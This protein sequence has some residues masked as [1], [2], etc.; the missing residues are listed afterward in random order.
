MLYGFRVEIEE[1]DK[2]YFLR[3]YGD[4]QQEVDDFTNRIEQNFDI[5]PYI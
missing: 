3:I 1:N 5:S 4:S 2:G